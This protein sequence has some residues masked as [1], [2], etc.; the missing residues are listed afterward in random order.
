[1]KLSSGTTCILCCRFFCVHFLPIDGVV[2][3]VDIGATSM[4][5]QA[6]PSFQ[7]STPAPSRIL[8]EVSPQAFD[9]ISLI[10][11]ERVVHLF[12][13][14]SAILVNLPLTTSDSTQSCITIKSRV[15]EDEVNSR[16]IML[17]LLEAT[18][19]ST[20]IRALNSNPNPNPPDN[21]H[22][23]LSSSKQ[24]QLL[25]QNPDSSRDHYIALRKACH[26]D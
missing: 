12:P 14:V 1:M 2:C 19:K 7:P 13:S 4:P 8:F 15:P 6:C 24:L 20:E 21:P 22:R 16:A 11:V 23:L 9:P 5:Q 17:S 25:V 10:V 3:L 26:H 18:D